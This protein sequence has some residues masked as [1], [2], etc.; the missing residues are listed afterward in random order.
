M[1]VTGRLPLAVEIAAARARQVGAAQVAD[2]LASGLEA[3]ID[4]PGGPEDRTAT[5]S[6]AVAWSWAL[7]TPSE[8]SALRQLAVF[9][10]GFTVRDA[11]AVVV[12]PEGTVLDAIHALALHHLVHPVAGPGRCL[13]LHPTVR[14]FLDAHRAPGER[15]GAEARHAAWF[16][17]S[18]VGPG[19][20]PL[21]PGSRPLREN[22][23]AAFARM[24]DRDPALAALLAEQVARRRQSI[25]AGTLVEVAEAGL[26][27]AEDPQVR[28]RIAS[29]AA[30]S[31][32]YL[33]RYGR[34]AELASL[35]L[36]AA[37]T[38]R[39]RLEALIPH[40]Q[41]RR[42]AGHF[43]EAEAAYREAAGL[44]IRLGA[45]NEQGRA[46]Y[47]LGQLQ[48]ARGRVEAGCASLRASLGAYD[49][50]DRMGMVGRCRMNLGYT[51]AISQPDTARAELDRAVQAARS[52]DET[53][54]LAFALLYR[55]TAR[56]A[57]GQLSEAGTDLA[58]AMDLLE[59]MGFQQPRVQCACHRAA[60]LAE[61]GHLPEA[62]AVL[63]G[64]DARF[65]A[66]LAPWR[67]LVLVLAGRRDEA[68]ALLP[69]E[70]RAAPRTLDEA[71]R[72]LVIRIARAGLDDAT[73]A[74]DPAEASAPVGPAIQASAPYA[75]LRRLL[76]RARSRSAE[77]R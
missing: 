55:G 43:D 32:G 77:A 50:T 40:A 30:L 31:V 47:L 23:L 19:S 14:A 38:P 70:P 28:G 41:A 16:A 69:P 5:L 7:L 54:F 51:L 62:L 39:E 48:L 75:A 17:S 74:A 15:R 6:A 76:A 2:A 20:R 18:P 73:D 58:E 13:D 45:P 52:L 49:R 36:S 67:A 22:L 66:T 42:R 64:H 59:A 11:E 10:G 35:G 37:R 63:G 44:A 72:D 24:R 12:V 53:A 27:L 3:L 68:S 57:W 34:M 29:A 8:R 4:E 65:A 60:V 1:G 21:R 33:G 46:L 25:P 71:L 26:E 9:R 61:A 56:W